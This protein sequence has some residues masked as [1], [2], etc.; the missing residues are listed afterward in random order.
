MFITST[1]CPYDMKKKKSQNVNQMRRLLY[2]APHTHMHVMKTKQ[3][4]LYK[5]DRQIDGLIQ[6]WCNT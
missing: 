5:T 3:D 4:T 2:A 6:F 1:L